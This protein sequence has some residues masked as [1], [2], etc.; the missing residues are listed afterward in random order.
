M[1]PFSKR[2]CLKKTGPNRVKR[3]L[4]RWH[5]LMIMISFAMPQIAM[6]A[7]IGLSEWLTAESGPALTELSIESP[8]FRG[9]TVVIRELHNDIPRAASNQLSAQIKRWLKQKLLSDTRLRIPVE[10]TDLCQPVQADIVLGI[11][12]ETLNEKKHS[13]SLAFLDLREGIWINQS[14]QNWTGRLTDAQRRALNNPLDETTG[15]TMATTAT[16][17]VQQPEEIAQHLK[18]ALDSRYA[19][20]QQLPSPLMFVAGESS[21]TQK[22]IEKLKTK[23]GHYPLTTDPQVA[24]S[25]LRIIE[26]PT[27]IELRAGTDATALLLASVPLTTDQTEIRTP[28]PLLSGIS[29]TSGQRLCRRQGRECI[30]LGYEVQQKSWIYQ[31][32]TQQGSLVP[33]SCQMPTRQT[34]GTEHIGLKVRETHD[35]SRP[36]LGFY[37]LATDNTRAAQEVA[38]LL[39]T[40]DQ[41]SGFSATDDWRS[42]LTGLINQYGITWQAVHLQNVNGPT[43]ISQWGS[44]RD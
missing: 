6:T 42:A 5:N 33:V 24:A 29:V 18:R 35:A 40:T 32:Y 12:I 25:L 21:N 27:T 39:N 14:M 8:R 22:I 2:I 11:K 20:Q 41:C 26:T 4:S 34:R 15:Q 30:E 44:F 43:L 3:S 7:P 16:F 37:V 36:S 9:E 10:N 38:Q 19:C 28:A 13:V 17:D 23:L 1:T 31:F